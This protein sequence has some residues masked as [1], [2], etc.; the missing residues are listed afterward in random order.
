MTLVRQQQPDIVC[1]QEVRRLNDREDQATR[2]A[3]G[4]G[5]KYMAS[6]AAIGLPRKRWCDVAVL[7]R[8]PIVKAATLA[9]AD[10]DDVYAIIA[11]IDAPGGQLHVVSVHA[12]SSALVST[13]YVVETSKV[14]LAQLQRLIAVIG[15]YRGD[16]LIVGDINAM[17][18]MP[19]YLMLASQYTPLSTSPD[20]AALL[21][22]PAHKPRIQIDHVFGRGPFT[23]RACRAI[24]SRASDHRPIVLEL[25]RATSDTPATKPAN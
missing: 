12:K 22:F 23:T 24:D 10:D 14:R 3:A 9:L 8:W 19:G 13:G 5:L 18:L 16:V 17:P 15:T 21:T 1:L 20:P 6:P 4:A 25:S 11:T 2:I 7:S